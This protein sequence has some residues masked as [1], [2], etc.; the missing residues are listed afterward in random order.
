MK[1]LLLHASPAPLGTLC[2]WV[3]VIR[4]CF[5]GIPSSTTARFVTFCQSCSGIAPASNVSK[6]ALVNA[7]VD[8]DRARIE[9]VENAF[10]ILPQLPLG[11]RHVH[12]GSAARK[13]DAGPL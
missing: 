9:V 11:R 1:H 3:A 6:A 2:E 8:Y 13:A 10:V 4:M 12:F 5:T 7:V